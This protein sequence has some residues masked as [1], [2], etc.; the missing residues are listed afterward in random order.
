[1]TDTGRLRH[2]TLVLQPGETVIVEPADWADTL[3]AVRSGEL[4]LL[5]RSGRRARFAAGA[6]LTLAGLPVL[7][8]RNPGPA[9]LTLHAVSRRRNR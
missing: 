1:M 2:R 3:V 9:K 6:V 4:E 5:C 8:L 7:T